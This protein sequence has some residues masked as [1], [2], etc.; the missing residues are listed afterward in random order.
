MVKALMPIKVGGVVRHLKRGS[1]YE[2][3][4]RSLLQIS[5]STIARL[6]PELPIIYAVQIAQALESLPL[7]TYLA[8][9]DDTLWN[10][11]ESEFR[12]GRFVEV[13]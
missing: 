4:G 8:L 13:E 2:I 9:A 3:Q 10:R 6:C 12:D 7:V 1:K 11:P 5:G